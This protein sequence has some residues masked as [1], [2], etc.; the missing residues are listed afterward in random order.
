MSMTVKHVQ[1]NKRRSNS[2]K[3][4]KVLFLIGFSLCIAAGASAQDDPGDPNGEVD[5][6]F[7]GGISL[8]VAAGVAYGA[9]QWHSNRKEKNGEEEKVEL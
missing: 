5:V 2:K 6:P 1:P 8:L 3:I 9:K 4:S 7:D